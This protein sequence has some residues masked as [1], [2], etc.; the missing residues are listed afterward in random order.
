[1]NTKK[2]K[3]ITKTI[4]GV[5]AGLLLM[6]ISATAQA[7]I[8]SPSGNAVPDSISTSHVFRSAGTRYGDSNLANTYGNNNNNHDDDEHRDENYDKKDP[9]HKDQHNSTSPVPI[10]AAIWLLGSGL[11]GL[12]VMR[13]RTKT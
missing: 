10:P 9:H 4:I 2:M 5:I 6:T 11:M 8:A 3:K 1:M 12:A 7:I 13:R